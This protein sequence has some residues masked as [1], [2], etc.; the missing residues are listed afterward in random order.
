MLKEYTSPTITVHS[1]LFAVPIYQKLGFVQ[2]DDVKEDE[3]RF[4]NLL[5]IISKMFFQYKDVATTMKYLVRGIDLWSE[6][7]YTDDDKDV[8]TFEALFGLIDLLSDEAQR[9]ANKDIIDF[10]AIFAEDKVNLDSVFI[11]ALKKFYQF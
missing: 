10:D 4:N 2:I 11:A 5:N 9:D 8:Y 6:L 1:S 7:G 3:A